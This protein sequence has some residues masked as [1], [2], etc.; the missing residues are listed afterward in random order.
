MTAGSETTASGPV[1]ELTVI[2]KEK[3]LLLLFPFLFFSRKRKKHF[4]PP[5][6]KINCSSAFLFD[7]GA[8]NVD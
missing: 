5:V 3:S 4:I 1:K 7:S 8:S 2:R 6:S